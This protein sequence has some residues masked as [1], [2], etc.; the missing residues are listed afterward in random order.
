MARV[1]LVST[2][3][4][5]GAFRRRFAANRAFGDNVVEALFWAM[6]GKCF[7]MDKEDK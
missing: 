3:G 6:R 4:R 2:L 7:I 5:K 1:R